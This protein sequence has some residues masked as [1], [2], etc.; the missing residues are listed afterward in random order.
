MLSDLK[1]EMLFIFVQTVFLQV[2]I[3]FLKRSRFYVLL[4]FYFKKSITNFIKSNL[5]LFLPVNH[6]KKLFESLAKTDLD[7]S[8]EFDKIKKYL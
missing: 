6:Q 5:V 8:K 1:A 3:R 7:D 2:V 4:N